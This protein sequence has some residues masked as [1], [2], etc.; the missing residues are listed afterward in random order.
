MGSNKKPF[1]RII[2]AD[3]RS[4]NEGSFIEEI[5]WY[6]PRKKEG[7]L[8]L[9]LAKADAWIAKGAQPS[10]TVASFI[11]QARKAQA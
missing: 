3:V 9:D 8:K 4:A 7:N 11:K 5:G 10:E 6:D 1:F 2:A